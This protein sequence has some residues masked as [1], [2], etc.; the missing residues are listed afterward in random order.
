MN[1]SENISPNSKIRLIND[2]WAEIQIEV[3]REKQHR[4]QS[5]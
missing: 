3:E 1:F 2:R 5:L 4:H